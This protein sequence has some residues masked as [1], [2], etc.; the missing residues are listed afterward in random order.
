MQSSR[1]PNCLTKQGGGEGGGA[2]EG[3]G[4]QT[5]FSRSGTAKNAVMGGGGSVGQLGGGMMYYLGS[6][7]CDWQAVQLW[8]PIHL[9]S[10]GTSLLDSCQLCG[11]L[12]TVF[13][14]L[15]TELVKNRFCVKERGP[16]GLVQLL[17]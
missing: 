7:E 14:R 1:V 8:S 2:G 4:G 12:E 9:L 5:C 16:S 17:F 3:G 11:I 10:L 15:Y 6:G 13:S